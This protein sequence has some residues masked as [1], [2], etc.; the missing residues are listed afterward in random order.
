[1]NELKNASKAGIF[2][3]LILFAFTFI[4]HEISQTTLIINIS[5]GLVFSIAVYLFSTSKKIK[6]QV[7]LENV[8]ETEIIYSDGANHFLNREG[9]GGWLYLLSNKLV[10]KSHKFNLQNHTLEIPID[11]IHKIEFF[12]NLA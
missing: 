5:S 1:M 12:N 9:V 4:R 10:F 11:K 8:E 6:K 2:F 3:T 7:K